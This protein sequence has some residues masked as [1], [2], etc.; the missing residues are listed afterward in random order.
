M[1][2]D[3][4]AFP[5]LKSPKIFIPTLVYLLVKLFIRVDRISETLLFG[6]LCYFSLKYLTNITLIRADIIVPTALFFTFPQFNQPID[7]STALF[8]LEY[9]FIRLIIPLNKL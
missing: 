5:D 2:I 3:K 8:I 7:I 9:A 4:M 6:L 1:L